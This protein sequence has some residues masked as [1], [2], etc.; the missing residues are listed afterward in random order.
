MVKL[1]LCFVTLLFASNISAAESTFLLKKPGLHEQEVEEKCRTV[2]LKDPS[3]VS[4]YA[5]WSAILQQSLHPLWLSEPVYR[6]ITEYIDVPC[7]W[8]LSSQMPIPPSTACAYIPQ[9]ASGPLIAVG[10]AT[11]RNIQLLTC[12]DGSEVACLVGHSRNICE[13][14]YS[15]CN[16]M[17]ISNSKDGSVRLWLIRENGVKESKHFETWSFSGAVVLSPDECLLATRRRD[18]YVGIAPLLNLKIWTECHFPDYL[19]TAMV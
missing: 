14:V 2:T 17:L 3:P 18:G 16:T 4:Y 1:S 10:N 7:T 13:L 19:I 6:I 15:P 5:K 9:S 12:N 8:K 11:T